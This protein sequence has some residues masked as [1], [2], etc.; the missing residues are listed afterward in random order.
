M[1]EPIILNRRPGPAIIAQ[2]VAASALDYPFVGDV[3]A[4]LATWAR[5]EGCWAIAFH[6]R[7][8]VGVACTVTLD[9]GRYAGWDCLFWLEVLPEARGLG[10]GRALLT[11]VLDHH[12]ERLII[13]ATAGAAPFYAALLP[14]AQRSGDL[15]VVEAVERSYARVA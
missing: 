2:F 8:P 10:I 15:F 11:Q 7:R 5:G 12:G 6:E 1:T 13:S 4:R 9:D 14:Q 3:D